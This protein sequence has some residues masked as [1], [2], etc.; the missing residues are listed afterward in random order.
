MSDEESFTRLLYYGIVH[1]NRSEDETWLMP[2][3]LLMDFVECH[4]QFLGMAKPKT[5]YE[6][7]DILP[8]DI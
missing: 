8:Q 3:G 1:L 6:L 5:E 4:R 2:F 7:D